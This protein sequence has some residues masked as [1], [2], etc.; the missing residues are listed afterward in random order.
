MP[1][2]FLIVEDQQDDVTILKYALLKTGLHNPLKVVENGREAIDYLSGTGM[3]TD[4][5]KYPMP[6]L[7]FLDLKLPIVNGFD[8]LQWIRKQP[9]LAPLV[10]VVL[11]ASSTEADITKA[12]RLG[13]H[14]YVVKPASLELFLETLKDFRKWWFQYEKLKTAAPKAMKLDVSGLPAT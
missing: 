14:S 5:K 8:V 3:Y 1:E 12:Y 7:I 10:V 9:D 13:A 2:T 4:R 6:S 11:S